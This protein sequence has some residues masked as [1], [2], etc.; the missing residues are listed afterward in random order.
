MG[1]FITI[2]VLSLWIIYNFCTMIFP[3]LPYLSLYTG[4][5]GMIELLNMIAIKWSGLIGVAFLVFG[6]LGC[7]FGR[8]EENNFSGMKV[9]ILLLSIVFSLFLAI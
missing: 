4:G 6:I 8:R 5:N 3:S 9:P 1:I 2:I 7:I